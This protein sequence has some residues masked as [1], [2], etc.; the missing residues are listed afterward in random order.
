MNLNRTTNV[1]INEV[2]T[3]NDD[4]L[5]NKFG[6]SQSKSKNSRQINKNLSQTVD[7]I[8]FRQEQSQGPSI[9]QKIF[10]EES[11]QQAVLPVETENID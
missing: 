10:V 8:S 3:V 6:V 5:K 4:F 2:E 9:T 1:N 7:S 11:K